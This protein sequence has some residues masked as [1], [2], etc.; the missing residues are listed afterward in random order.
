M[1]KRTTPVLLLSVALTAYAGGDGKLVGTWVKRRTQQEDHA[2]PGDANWKL[3]VSFQPNSRFVWRST[4]TEGGKVIDESVRGTYS[5]KRG[6]IAFRFQKPSPAA[7]KRLPEWFAYWPAK[8]K[9][10]QSLRLKDDS[11]VLGHDGNK[12]WFHLRRKDVEKHRS[13]VRGEPRR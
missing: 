4:R 12:L 6:L 7:R 8:L 3:E 13:S 11:L 2:Y 10:Q 5:V 1:M 9:G